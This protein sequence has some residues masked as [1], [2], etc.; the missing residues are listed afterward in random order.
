MINSFD[1]KQ[2]LE[3]VGHGEVNEDDRNSGLQKDGF[4]NRGVFD[5]TKNAREFKILI[6]IDYFASQM[7]P[8]CFKWQQFTIDM[9]ELTP[10]ADT[11]EYEALVRES[12]CKETIK[13][14]ERPE[15]R[16]T[17]SLITSE[18]SLCPLYPDRKG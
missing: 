1:R 10:T 18:L 13:S 7:S 17:E 3:L 16:I 11:L 9:T 6:V 2:C 4:S 12:N 5:H 8:K 15:D 14:L